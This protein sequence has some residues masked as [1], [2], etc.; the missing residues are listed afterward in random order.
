MMP[1][2]KQAHFW[3]GMAIYGLAVVVLSP[4]Y[5]LLPVVVAGV[6]KELWDKRT[7]P[8][9]WYDTL[10]TVGGGCV[11]LLWTMIV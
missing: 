7:H 3:A 11:A 1:L 5:S 4:L 2:A 6:G 9:D 10:Y 8:A